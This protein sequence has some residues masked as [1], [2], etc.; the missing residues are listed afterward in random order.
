MGHTCQRH[1]RLD[2]K[3]NSGVNHLLT[4]KRPFFRVALAA[5]LSIVLLPP[6]GSGATEATEVGSVLSLSTPQF[7][8]SDAA[9]YTGQMVDNVPANLRD[10]VDGAV[11]SFAPIVLTSAEAQAISDAVD[12]LRPMAARSVVATEDV[13][14]IADV[15]KAPA[16][17]QVVVT[18]VELTTGRVA[19]G[20]PTAI[21]NAT[22]ATDG[23][24]SSST[25][26]QTSYS[27]APAAGECQTLCTEGL[28][29][30]GLVGVFVCSGPQAIACGLATYAIGDAATGLCDVPPYCAGTALQYDVACQEVYACILKGEGAKL[31]ARYSSSNITLLWWRNGHRMD[32]LNTLPCAV[33]YSITNDVF[34]A[35]QTDADQVIPGGLDRIYRYELTAFPQGG[36]ACYVDQTR[37]VDV[38]ASVY[39]TDGSASHKRDLDNAKRSVYC[40]YP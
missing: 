34:Y 40:R 36:P 18:S 4:F 19:F 30:G 16:S 12:P 15:F 22:A 1:C 10:L 6:M 20:T 8:S 7:S 3:L 5:V 27:M 25:S 29:A 39:W 31:N 24:V 13:A 2:C 17:V 33:D 23:L 32:C 38:Y 26:P 28:R 11:V 37:W 21:G 14:V 9:T 35:K